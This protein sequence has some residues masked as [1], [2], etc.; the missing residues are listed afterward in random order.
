MLAYLAVRGPARRDELISILWGEIPEEKAR[1]AFRQSLHRLRAILGEEIL[2]QDRDQVTLRPERQLEID[3]EAFVVA[4][5]H[6]RW[7]TAISR[8]GGEF[9]EGF[10]ADEPAFDRW[11]DAERVRLRNRYQ[12]ALLAAGTEAVAEGRISDAMGHARKLVE[13]APYDEDAALFEANTLVAAG[14]PS[15]AVARLTEFTA[16]LREELDI[17]APASV[18][19]LVE[20]LERRAALRDTPPGATPSME[21]DRIFVGRDHELSRML[22]LIGALKAERGAT[23][24]LEGESGIGKSRLLDEFSDRARNLGGILILRGQEAGLSG[25]LPYAALADALRPLVRAAGVAGASRHLLSEA[26][27]LLP[28]LRDAFELPPTTPIEDETGRLRFFEGVAA[29]VDA[30]AYEKPVCLIIDDAQ[31]ASQSSTDLLVYLSR[32][33][34][35]SPVLLVLAY[36][37]D[38]GALQ[39]VDRLRELRAADTESRI[40]L[41]ALA[42]ADSAA[43]AKALLEGTPQNDE[44]TIAQIVRLGNGRPFA[45]IELARNASTGALPTEV[46]ATMRD[47]LWARFQGASPSQRRIFFA[48]ALYE[49]ATSLRLLAAAAHLPETTAFE[50]AE[51]LVHLGL[52]RHTD[53]GLGIAHDA[54]SSFLVES[55]GL[56]GRAML[57]GWAGDAL[58]AEPRHSESELASLYA[59]AGRSIEAFKHARAGAFAAAAVGAPSETSRLLGIALTFAPN[60]AARQEIDSLLAAFGRTRLTLPRASSESVEDVPEEP[61]AD[62]APEAA[63]EIPAR[64]TPPASAPAIEAERR[65][66]RLF[67]RATTRQW[68]ISIAISLAIVALGSLARREIMARSNVGVIPD[69]L[70]L[71]ERDA[72]GQN[73]LRIV[74]DAR[75]QQEPLLLTT[76]RAALGPEWT[77]SLAS[78]W[79]NPLV[80]PDLRTVAL[81]RVT[82][83]GNEVVVVS[84]DRRDTTVVAAGVGDNTALGWSPDSR[85]LLYSRSRT[86]SD[87]GLGLDLY[88]VDVNAPTRTWAIDTSSSRVIAREAEWSP[89]G[90]WIAWVVATGPTRQR[91]VLVARA[92]GSQLRNVSV[93]P[94]DDYDISWSPDGSLLAFTS[95]RN[96]A[97]RVYVYDLEAGRLWPPSSQANEGRAVFSPDGRSIAVESTR[98][99][100]L[101]VYVRPALGGTA[102]RITPRGRQFSATA[103]R[104]G[105]STAYVD[106]LRIIGAGTVSP[107]DSARLDLIALTRDGR[108][109]T[110]TGV[111]WHFLDHG[112]VAPTTSTEDDTLSLVAH[113]AARTVGEARIVAEIPGWRSDTVVVVSTS[114]QPLHIADRFEKPSFDARW[115]PLGRPLPVIG[116]LPNGVTAAFPNGDLEWD[117]GLL[118]RQSLELRPGLRVR[119]RI[120][121]PFVGRPTQAT[122]WVGFAAG[123]GTLDSIAPRLNPLVFA[124]WDGASGNLTYTVG[125]ETSS[126]AT[127]AVA[128]ADSHEIEIRVNDDRSVVFS[129][130]GSTR[131]TSSLNFL[132][133]VQGTAVRLWIGGRA[134][135]SSVAVSDFSLDQPGRGR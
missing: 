58:L 64:R 21:R 45:I 89:N 74:V 117:S 104:A 15:Q 54:T 43:L 130:D 35:Q 99:G 67:A 18:R 57:A 109:V 36:R 102:R 25:V 48:A 128:S 70:Y 10:E 40:L 68:T 12:E 22:G 125:R 94:A 85:A 61:G 119:V 106:R 76:S 84:A 91:E 108:A 118:L 100:D 135:G 7:A 5:E 62:V 17:P 127:T 50:A 20:R 97:T 131:W 110:P 3:R 32:R 105:T 120:H 52:L 42:P 37:S 60:E 38:R 16:R 111:R 6:G 30:A 9:L 129:V 56:A 95:A 11:A 13:A 39:T 112:T 47:V 49:R 31:H 19:A 87:G 34:Q 114:T 115:L 75:R 132:G 2:P 72:R 69:T 26:A 44:T 71:S 23:I 82:P 14:R 8:Y 4:C 96:N 134:T 66:R 107:G 80:A 123:Q 73:A 126:E 116:R 103:W 65:R 101:A 124:A 122:M 1:N 83:R 93:N 41:D 28:E 53:E 24:L 55:S 121:A 90:A 27:R 98:E 86:L 79:L 29:L 51:E 81:H 133:D 77:D 92:D 63:Q 46:P 33:L 113:I 78:P 59:M 88:A